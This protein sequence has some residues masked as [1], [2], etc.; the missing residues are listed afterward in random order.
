MEHRQRHSRLGNPGVIHKA[1]IVGSQGINSTARGTSPHEEGQGGP[2]SEVWS[3]CVSL[4]G[5]PS[6]PLPLPATCVLMAAKAHTRVPQ[7]TKGGTPEQY[8]STSTKPCF[9]IHS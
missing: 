2:H 6:L 4:G 8:Y 7:S 5:L 9:S 3:T 1:F